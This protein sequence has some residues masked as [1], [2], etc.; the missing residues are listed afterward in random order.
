MKPERLHHAGNYDVQEA[1]A[2]IKAKLNANP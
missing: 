2:W 1:F